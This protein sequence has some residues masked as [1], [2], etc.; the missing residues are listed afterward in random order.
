MTLV[1]STCDAGR[2]WGKDTF[3]SNDTTTQSTKPRFVPS[4]AD[5]QN[6]GEV[7]KITITP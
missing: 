4:K 2:L 3:I 1:I 7:R 5:Q 6:L